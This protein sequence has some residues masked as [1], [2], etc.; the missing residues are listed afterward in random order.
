MANARACECFCLVLIDFLKNFSYEVK[1]KHSSGNKNINE[2]Q[3]LRYKHK[4]EYKV[5]IEFIERF[6]FVA[7]AFVSKKPLRFLTLS[8]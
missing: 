6:R 3:K 5:S 7:C 4:K 1:R 2:R 8:S